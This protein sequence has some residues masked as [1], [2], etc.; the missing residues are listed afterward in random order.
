MG[1]AA[2]EGDL[3]MAVLSKS[4]YVERYLRDGIARGQWAP[5]DRL[6]NDQDICAQLGVSPST[7]ANTMAR[8]ASEGLLVRRQRLGTCVSPNVK[9]GTIAVLSRLSALTSPLGYYYREV[10]E[11]TQRQVA[12]AGYRMNVET[13]HGLT[14]EAFGDSIRLFDSTVARDL[15]GVISTLD[16]G[17]LYLQLEKARVPYVSIVAQRPTHGPCV[18]FDRRALCH[19]GVKTLRA[20]RY[21]R[22]VVFWQ[23]GVGTD[24]NRRTGAE[25]L[26]WLREADPELPDARFVAVPFSHSCGAAYDVFAATWKSQHPDAAFFLD[27][28]MFD[29]A[30]R[31]ISDLKIR[32]PE[33]LALV[34][35]TNVGRHFHFRSPVARIEYDPALAVRTAWGMLE[36]LIGKQPLVKSV[37]FQ[38]PALRVLNAQSQRSRTASRGSK[39]EQARRSA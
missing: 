35:M 8:L 19:M 29:V 15:L 14:S 2:G 27:D 34:T 36:R 3:G 38:G 25:L 6:P 10:I 16:M 17:N 4:A 22:F 13:G 11:Q 7:L 9:T 1:I 33:E 37:V 24:E 32:V 20:Q 31:A 39:T 18:V 21:R 30:S 5:G 23:E 28:G 12:Q 26:A